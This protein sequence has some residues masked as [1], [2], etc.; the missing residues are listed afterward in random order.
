M[1]I[2]RDHFGPAKDQLPNKR[3]D[4]V[5]SPFEDGVKV[6]L[7]ANTPFGISFKHPRLGH[8]GLRYDSMSDE[9]YA[10]LTKPL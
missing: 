2:T 1:T 8:C 4:I 3:G 10:R 7:L 9:Q 5:W 6:E